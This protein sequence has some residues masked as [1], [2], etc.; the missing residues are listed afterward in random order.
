MSEIQHW[1]E[2]VFFLDAGAQK[3]RGRGCR[4]IRGAAVTASPG[5]SARQGAAALPQ[6]LLLVRSP[7]R[8]LMS[9]C[10][11][12]PRGKREEGKGRSRMPR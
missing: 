4:E 2:A 11:S 12:L 6:P 3:R 7:E 8:L 1:F 9:A 10:V 5:V